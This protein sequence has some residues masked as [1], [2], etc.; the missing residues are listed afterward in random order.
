MVRSLD[1]TGRKK[2]EKDSKSSRL[3]T[4]FSSCLDVSF[5]TTVTKPVE[6]TFSFSCSRSG[7]ESRRQV[8]RHSEKM[9]AAATEYGAAIDD[10]QFVSPPKVLPV[11]Q[12]FIESYSR[13]TVEGKST[14]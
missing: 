9:L 8:V 2:K 13:P 3:G 6:V 7:A 10:I 12:D 4:W 1:S 14:S 5:P 11:D